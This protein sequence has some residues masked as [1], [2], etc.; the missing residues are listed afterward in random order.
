MEELE[1]SPNKIATRWAFIAFLIMVIMIYGFYFARVDAQSPINYLGYVPFGICLFLAIKEHRD[2]DLGGYITFGR[3]FTT[4]FKYSSFLSMLMGLFMLVYLK[5]L[6]ADV[7]NDGLLL[8]E[9]QM[10]DQGKSSD[11]IEMAMDMARKWGPYFAAI[12]TSIMYT[13]SGAVV[14]IVCAAI[15]KKD[16][17]LT[18]D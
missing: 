6:N 14:S 8:A 16:A 17:P 18:N 3:S 11:E 4:G 2:Q 13:L 7:F 9:N 1:R 5:W 10:I 12:T 15:L